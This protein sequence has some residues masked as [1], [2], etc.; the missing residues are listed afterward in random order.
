[1]QDTPTALMHHVGHK[2]HEVFQLKQGR[3]ADLSAAKISEMMKSNSLDNAP[4]QSLLSV[5]NGILDESIE[6]KN[7]EIPH[8]VAC[9]LRKVVQ[10]IERRISTQ[11]EHLRTQ[12][13]LFKSREEKYQSRIR[14][15]ETLA[16]GTGEEPETPKSTTPKSTMD[17]MKKVE[18]EYMI[19]LMKE[20]EQA[21][22]ELSTLKRDL[23]IAKKEYELEKSK[24]D[25]ERKLGSEDV[26]KLIKEK[27]QTDIELSTLKQQFELEK[28]KTDAE[29]TLGSGDVIKKL[30]KEKEQTDIELS[31]LKQQFELE[32]SKK[33][34]EKTVGSEDV[35]KLMKEKEQTD[36]ELSTLKQQL[37][38]EMSKRD[39][40]KTLDSEEVIK[41][42]KEKEQTDIELS[43]LKRQ[44]EIARKEYEVEKS[45]WD[46]E[47]KFGSEDV[48]KLMKEKEQ[49][50]IEISR[51]KRDFDI[52]IKE[53][54]LEKSK[55]DEE[56]KLGSED[57]TKL[58]KEKEQIDIELSTVKQELEIANRTHDYEKSQKDEEGRL[59]E[60]Q[61]IKLKKDKE[62]IDVALAA[63]KK[64]LETVLETHELHCLKMERAAK[65]V[66][67]DLEKR[68]KDLEH[69][70]EDSRNKVKALEAYTES[71]NKMWNKKE[72]IFNSL[73]E[74]QSGKL[75]ELKFSSSSIKSEIMR[76]QKSYSE[77]FAC[78]GSKFKTLI[79]ASENYHL[80][81]AE[82]RKMF[83]ELQDLKGNIRVY[84]RIRPLIGGQPG[85]PTTIDHIGENGELVVANP[86]KPGKDGQRLFRFNKLY[87]PNSTQG[88]VFSDTQPLI[89]CV[90][91]GY[92][93]CIFAYGQTGSGKTYTMTGPNG[94]TEEDW[95]VNYRALND[96]FLI[97]Q[98]RNSS[99]AYNVGVQMFEIYNES[100]RDLLSNDGSP[101][102]LGIKT[103]PQA[104]G[105]AVPDASM[106]H[107]TSTADVI[108]LMEIGLGNRAVSATALNERSSRSHSV[109]SIHVQGKDLHTGTTLQGNLHLVDLAGSERV[110]RSEVTGDRLREAQHINKSLSALGDVIFSLA[111][112][113]SHVP[114]RNSKLT[115]LLQAS[116]GGQA[117]TLMFVQLNPDTNSYFETMSTLKFAER[118][119]GVE[120]GA[121]KSSKEGRDIRELMEQ[122][123]TLKD[124]IAKKDGE[125]ERLQLVKD[126]KSANPG[127]GEKEGK[128]LSKP[129]YSPASKSS[130]GSQRFMKSPSD[131]GRSS[132]YSELHMEG[133]LKWQV[134]A[135][136][137]EILGEGDGDHD[138]RL[139]DHMSDGGFSTGADPDVSIDDSTK[140]P[141]KPEK[142]KVAS[143][144]RS[145]QRLTQPPATVSRNLS[146]VPSSVKKTSSTSTAAK[147][148]G[149]SW[150]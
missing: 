58:M 140:P 72:V 36:I 7:A 1:M 132:E 35:L 53:Y 148:T 80:V 10:E 22:F 60:E 113:S 3:Y 17:G 118:V 78:L 47:K 20:K 128:G 46:E 5:V 31:T 81:L 102:K 119:S 142:N 68:I 70:L 64:E 112:K 79:Q 96:L 107:V 122:V 91:D 37:E 82:N 67:D 73:V 45:N 50:D 48:T 138:D 147:S 103:T 87:G 86:T 11:A 88:E 98:N 56:R 101:K 42:M 104:N 38:L 127:N 114:Y 4:T 111:Q 150:Q 18:E 57:V 77:D 30:M 59:L 108:E 129:A 117:K 26:I 106:H 99:F 75:E 25:E 63:L 13:N 110:D 24:R 12:N 41:L 92:N 39:A 32:K 133:R 125:I 83:N 116:L 9:L 40:E 2:F 123:A 8:R 131:L 51:L 95:G 135:E 28:S 71:K 105:L 33:D 145:L 97:S 89:R 141:D 137:V 124:T 69:T 16:S 130:D 66:Q 76:T 144:I 109:V 44:F 126:I 120:L 43:T 23:D 100:L 143:R 134:S 19:K 27:E 52:A 90:L 115:Q 93:V 84:C 85:K 6:R 74:F 62:Q 34:A 49:A 146:R 65:N 149:R 121:A 29:K 21:N 14:V 55:R 61:I 136:D 54:E 139:S 15:L 94:A